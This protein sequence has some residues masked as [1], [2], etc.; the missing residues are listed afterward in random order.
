MDT[1][2]NFCLESIQDILKKTYEQIPALELA[3]LASADGFSLAAAGS[4]S[5]E[6]SFPEKFAAMVSS[7][8]ALSEAV[9]KEIGARELNITAVDFEDKQIVLCAIRSDNQSCS[10]VLAFVAAQDIL[11]GNLIWAI[12][13]CAEEIKDTLR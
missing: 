12:R 5:K 9:G 6:N 13:Q 7:M 11:L 3:A 8:S 2:K 10:F 1:D 4:K